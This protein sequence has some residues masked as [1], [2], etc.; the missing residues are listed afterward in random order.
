MVSFFIPLPSCKLTWLAGK[1]THHF[2]GMKPRKDGDFHG[3]TVSFREGT[4]G[5]DPN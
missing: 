1:W 3:R 2:D 4:W 5:T